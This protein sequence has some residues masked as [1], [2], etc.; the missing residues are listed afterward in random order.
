MANKVS[1]H[2]PIEGSM[3]KTCAFMVHRIIVPFNE[4]EYGIDREVLNIPEDEE[5]VYEHY[6]CKECGFD[7][8]HLVKKCN[9]YQPKRRNLLNIDL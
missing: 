7:L 3:C 8:D 4:A 9:L 2:D 6:F 5:I 1:T